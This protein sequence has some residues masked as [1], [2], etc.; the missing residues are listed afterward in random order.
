L[1][2]G[3]GDFLIRVD[4]LLFVYVVYYVSL[5]FIIYTHF[6]SCIKMSQALWVEYR[7]EDNVQICMVSIDDCIL[8][9]DLIQKIRNTS[10]LSVPKNLSITLSAPS[11]TIISADECPSS[12]ISGNSRDTPIQVRVS[13]PL[14]VIEEQARNSALDS[15]WGSLH[16]LSIEDGFLNFSVIPEF[17]PE[18]MKSLYV[19]EAYEDLFKIIWDRAYI[20]IPQVRRHR[21][22]IAGTPGIGKSVFLFYVLWRLAKAGIQKVVLDR[23]E[24][25]ESNYYIFRSSVC[26]ATSDFSQMRY[27]LNDRHCWYL[28][29]SHKN[30]SIHSKPITISM[31]WPIKRYFKWFALFPGTAKL[32]F[33]PPWSYEEME[34]MACHYSKDRKVFKDRF[35]MM[36][37]NPRSSSRKRRI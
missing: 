27:V 14:P 11:G 4:F 8:I 13:V 30:K 22:V 24:G 21:T 34:I 5:F 17:F 37:G 12:L 9:K 18:G 31:T 19:R 6:C 2:L 28:I 26:C 32:H 7:T 20:K 15:F 29:D 25:L 23:G 3:N 1:D 33:L 35:D 16:K 36:G 10:R